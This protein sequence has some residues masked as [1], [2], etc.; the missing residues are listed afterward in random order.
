MKSRWYSFIDEYVNEIPY[1]AL[2]VI[3]EAFYWYLQSDCEDK[4]FSDYAKENAR[5]LLTGG[6]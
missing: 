6:E 4:A 2:S 5:K 3:L 1:K